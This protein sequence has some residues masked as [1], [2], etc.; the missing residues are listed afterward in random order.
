MIE[1]LCDAQSG[2]G[3]VG[4]I[5]RKGNVV[6]ATGGSWGSPL[7]MT[8]DGGRKFRTRKPP[9]AS[10]LRD[11]LPL[12]ESHAL[13]VGES[14]ALFE[15]KDKETWS[16]IET[17]TSVCLFAIERA[18]GSIWISGEA[19]FVLCS[20]DGTAWRKPRLGEVPKSLGRIQR[21]TNTFGALWLLG[22]DGR[23]AFLRSADGDP[24]LAPLEAGKP[25][26]GI[27]FSP[28]GVGV[29]VGDGGTVFR[30]TNKGQAWTAIESGVE[31]DIEDVAWHDGRFVAVGAEGMLLVSEDGEKFSKV[32]TNRDEHLWA[33]TSDGAGVLIGGD[34]GLVMRATTEALSAAKAIERAEE[35]DDEEDEEAE[36]PDA[37][38]LAETPLGEEELARASSRWIDE[39]KKYYEA[40]NA[41]VAQFY[42]EDGEEPALSEEPEETRKDMAAFVQRAAVQLNREKR[43]ADLRRMFPPSYEAFEYENIGKTIQPALY[44]DDGSILARVDGVVHRIENENIEPM[45][46]VACFGRSRDR[47]HFAFAFEDRIEIRG[48]LQRPAHATLA[49]PKKFGAPKTIDVFPDGERVL[50]ATETHVSIISQRGVER[51]HPDGDAEASSYVHAALSPD[52][53]TIACGDQDSAHRVFISEAGH[54]VLAAEVEPASSYPCFAMFHDDGAHVALSSCHFSRSATLSME[55]AVLAKKKKKALTLSA[56]SE[57]VTV[58]DD[59]RW[60]YS[61]VSREKGFLLGDRSGYAWYFAFDGQLLG[62]L[63]IG[64][65]MESMDVSAD[66]KTLLFGTCAGILAE[67]DRTI[68]PPDPYK[69]RSLEGAE[70]RRWVFWS[71]FPALVW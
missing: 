60:M 5:R 48:G 55:L 21:L 25:L 39:G 64:S 36:A 19:G 50:V 23:L 51:I 54:F 6:W 12:G 24:K 32:D 11:V 27:A 29:V 45:K 9:E 57:R 40:L 71:G 38:R 65:T 7:V 58:I 44:M 22:Y 20:A 26:T 46:G 49:L 16:K 43:F 31:E 63:H 69:V 67:L 53:R 47:K 66:G 10:G 70:T 59:R 18:H 52:G 3:Y 41:F 62:Y 8:S 13:V 35:E 42:R 28:R 4:A 34:G 14:G 30:S 17:G 37:V 56:S 61:G 15:T 2:V 68:E 33:V 1:I